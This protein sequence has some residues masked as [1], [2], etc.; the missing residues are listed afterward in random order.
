[1]ACSTLKNPNNIPALTAP[2]AS[3]LNRPASL[4]VTYSGGGITSSGGHPIPLYE[5][6]VARGAYR[7]S[8]SEL[9][10]Q[11]YHVLDSLAQWPAVWV[12]AGNF[13]FVKLY[14]RYSEHSGRPRNTATTPSAGPNPRACLPK[15]CGA[16]TLRDCRWPCASKLPPT[17]QWRCEPG[18]AKL[19]TCRGTSRERV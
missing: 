10:G 18:P 15:W 5:G 13:A 17:S 6:L 4:D 11:A 12:V 1:M 2:L 3:L 7:M 8:K 14:L 19:T 9:N 16:C